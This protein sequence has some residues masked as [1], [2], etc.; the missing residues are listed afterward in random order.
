MVPSVLFG[1][2]SVLGLWCV[3]MLFGVIYYGVKGELIGN[4]NVKLNDFRTK[5]WRREIGL[6]RFKFSAKFI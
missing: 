2:V 3:S 5:F 6:H 4:F 1:A